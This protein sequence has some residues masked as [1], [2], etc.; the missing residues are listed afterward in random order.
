MQ[1]CIRLQVL[2]ELCL[3]FTGP[4]LLPTFIRLRAQMTLKVGAQSCYTMNKSILQELYNQIDS[5]QFNPSLANKTPLEEVCIRLFLS[6]T[7]ICLR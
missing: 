5:E 4:Q 7:I 2:C 6:F 1:L 3:F